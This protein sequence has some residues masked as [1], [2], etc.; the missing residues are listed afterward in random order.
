MMRIGVLANS[1]PTALSVYDEAEA[2]SGSKVRVL[3]FAA[4]G[5]SHLNSIAR[6]CARLLLKSGRWKSLR[7]IAA[8]KVFLLRKPL[9]HPE[10]LRR[11]REL[12]LDI[13]LHKSGNIYREATINC[14][15]VGILNA[16]IGLLPRYRGR[17]VMEWSLLQGDPVGIS[18][19]FIDSGIDTGARIVLSENVDISHCKSVAEAKEYLFNLDAIFYRRALELCRAKNMNHQNNDDS[20]RRFYVM[21]RLFQSAVEQGFNRQSAGGHN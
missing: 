10:T 14:F 19:F 20:G 3:L 18:V 4:N 21:S 5:K 9:T 15:R 8:H 17:S 16:H 13:G 12:N 2:I 1:L 6:H 11:L 7:L